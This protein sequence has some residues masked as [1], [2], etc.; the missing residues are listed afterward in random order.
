MSKL[1]IGLDT[2]KSVFHLV[3]KNENGRVIKKE[4]VKRHQLLSFFANTEILIV[5]VEACGA[6]HY[7]A[8]QIAAL[9]HDVKPIAPQYVTAYRKGNKSD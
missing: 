3:F 1:T 2:A 9:G 5:A 4:K 7:W 8:R 6:S